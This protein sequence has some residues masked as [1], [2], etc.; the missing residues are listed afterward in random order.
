MSGR[1]NYDR[2]FVGRFGRKAGVPSVR[3]FARDALTNEVGITVPAAAGETFGS[4]RDDDRAAAPEITPA[5]LDDL[6]FFLANLGA[7]PRTR[8]DEALEDAGAQVFERVG[9]GACHRALPDDAGRPVMLYSDLR[10]HDVAAPRGARRRRWGRDRAAL[11][12]FL[13]SL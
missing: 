5:A 12:A 3:E 13:R 2:G 6:A 8:A 7:P 9:C 4:A 11:V 10:L 1:A